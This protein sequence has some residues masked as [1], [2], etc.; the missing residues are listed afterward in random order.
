MGMSESVGQYATL[1]RADASARLHAL[2]DALEELTELEQQR[3]QAWHEATHDLRGNLG[4]VNNVT[5]V[6]Q[7]TGAQA[8][9]LQSSLAMLSRGVGSLRALLDDL[10]TQARPTGPAEQAKCEFRCRAGDL[11]TVRGHPSVA[12][13]HDCS[14]KAEDR[15]PDGRRRPSKMCRIAQNLLLNALHYTKHGGVEGKRLESVDSGDE[16]WV[17]AY[18]TPDRDR[19]TDS[20][21]LSTALDAATRDTQVL[22]K[23]A[24]ESGAGGDDGVEAPTLPSRSAP[25]VHRPG[26]GIGL[27]IVKRLC[28]LLDAS[29]EL[30]TV[31]RQGHHVPVPFPAP[32]RKG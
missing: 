1:Q 12:A 26:E 25:G 9:P 19:G 32:T 16:R 21:P 20:A 4:I 22:E 8:P 18:R 11:G 6:L 31:A 23:R 7:V 14:W 29:L 2:E 15:Q 30:Q 3:A 17:L 5:N 27:A 24:V 28:E 13:A 10:T